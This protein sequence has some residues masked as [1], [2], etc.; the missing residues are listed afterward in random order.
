MGSG[1]SRQSGPVVLAPQ[2][3]PLGVFHQFCVEGPVTIMI[4]ESIMS[5]SG[6]RPF[7]HETS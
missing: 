6:V 5:W 7:F 1:S 2:N 3:P 4:K